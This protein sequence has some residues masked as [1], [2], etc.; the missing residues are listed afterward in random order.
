MYQTIKIL[1]LNKADQALKNYHP[2]KEQSSIILYRSG[3][4]ARFFFF[5]G[6]GPCAEL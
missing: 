1:N 4:T 3:G 6:G 2:T 5:G